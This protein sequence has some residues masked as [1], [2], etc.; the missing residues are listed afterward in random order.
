ME[1]QSYTS[2]SYLSANQ[3][4]PGFLEIVE[5]IGVFDLFST[6]EQRTY[7]PD[8][9]SSFGIT[10]LHT[11]QP[12]LFQVLRYVQEK[13]VCGIGIRA[14][15]AVVH[16]P[17]CDKD[18]AKFNFS[19]EACGCTNHQDILRIPAQ[20]GRQGLRRPSR[21]I[22]PGKLSDQYTVDLIVTP[23][24]HGRFVVGVRIL[25]LPL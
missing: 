25:A 23:G 17:L 3:C 7:S 8:G 12:A 15:S 4:P 24:L 5:M 20:G 21:G 18:I 2:A 13:R 19:R 10:F 16:D 9:L 11:L 22:R 14:V 1:A 6:R